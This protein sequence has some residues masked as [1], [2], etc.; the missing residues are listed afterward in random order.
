[1]QQPL[2]V[3]EA[4]LQLHLL[5]RPE[6]DLPLVNASGKP[7]AGELTIQLT[8]FAGKASYSWT[9]QIEAAPGA[10]VQNIALEADRLAA[11]SPSDLGWELFSYG[12][13]PRTGSAFPAVQGTLQAA[14]VVKDSFELRLSA[15]NSVAYGGK[16]P[17]TAWLYDPGNGKPYAGAKITIEM[18]SR[19]G[20]GQLHTELLTRELITDSQGYVH[21][22]YDMPTNTAY[23]RGEAYA[24]ATMGGFQEFE[25]VGYAFEQQPRLILNT[26][27]PIY[28]PEQKVHLRALVTGVDKRAGADAKVT[29]KI[30]N[31]SGGEEFRSVVTTSRFG[32]AVA[33]W[34]IPQKAASDDYTV[35]ASCPFPHPEGSGDL[36]ANTQIR[37]AKYELPDFVVEVAPD[38]SYYLPGQDATVEVRGRYLT[39]QP[40][41]QAN[42]DVPNAATEHG[43]LDAGG[44][45]TVQISLKESFKRFP[46]NRW[47]HF[48]DAT[49]TAYLTDLSTGRTHSRSFT[50][51]LSREPVYPAMRRAHESL[52]GKQAGGGDGNS[53]G[54]VAAGVRAE[55]LDHFRSG[56]SDGV[57][58]HLTGHDFPV[59]VLEQQESGGRREAVVGVEHVDSDLVRQAVAEQACKRREIDAIG[60][61]AERLHARY[62]P[63]QERID[64][65][66]IDPWIDRGHTSSLT[67]DGDLGLAEA[68][69]ATALQF[70]G[71]VIRHARVP[72]L[73]PGLAL[74]YY[75]KERPFHIGWKAEGFG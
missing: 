35:T 30:T 28:Q 73:V 43:K 59:V 72:E 62:R 15:P 10:A 23:T 44:K 53:A 41:R 27:K 13:R 49:Y 20:T 1:L 12:I 17:V 48:E 64:T 29:F 26:D 54:N 69:A 56:G 32:V 31:R 58:C 33:D 4:S 50:L 21:T 25:Q 39:G 46:R 57:L 66:G 40:V 5:P 7:L 60:K 16:Y 70:V 6:L 3:D 11:K 67:V 38:R 68:R 18:L 24:K 36:R 22:E 65:A 75:I 55:V 37:I 2:R 51:R 74:R 45:F 52:H 71:Y 14:L 63:P 9:G 47:R 34:E 8:D 61:K 42:V 19:N